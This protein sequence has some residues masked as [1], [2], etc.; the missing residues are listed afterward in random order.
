MIRYLNCL[1]NI[2]C[3]V[4]LLWSL[5]NKW[6]KQKLPNQILWRVVK[7]NWTTVWRFVATMNFESAP[8]PLGSNR[9]EEIF[10]K[11]QFNFCLTLQALFKLFYLYRETVYCTVSNCKTVQPSNFLI[12]GNTFAASY[13][14][15]QEFF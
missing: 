14:T 11:F 8:L 12:I 9:V 4:C 7:P 1:V 6:Q 13:D 15:I 2:I 5:L 3:G 10:Q